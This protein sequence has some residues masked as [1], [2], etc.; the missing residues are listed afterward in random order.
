M[1]SNPREHKKA[2]RPDRADQRKSSVNSDDQ[3]DDQHD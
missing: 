3:G 1:A 2:N